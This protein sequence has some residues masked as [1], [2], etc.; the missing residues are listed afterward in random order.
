MKTLSQSLLIIILLFATYSV[1][2][3]TQETR[4]SE[5]NERVVILYRQ[6]N[7][8]EAA[9]LAEEVVKVAENSFGPE[10]PY[11]AQSLNNLALLYKVQGKYTEAEPLYKRSLS[12]REKALGPVHPDLATVLENMEACSRNLGEK[13]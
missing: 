6:G 11:V 1:S 8:S 3:Y 4:W 9:Q 12:I 2:A 10:H 5:L 13:R 7:Y